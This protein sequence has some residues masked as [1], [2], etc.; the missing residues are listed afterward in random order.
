[1]M[2]F[3]LPLRTP[4]L[5]LE[6]LCAHG[7]CEHSQQDSTLAP[8][9]GGLW[10]CSRPPPA[11]ASPL[12]SISKHKATPGLTRWTYMEPLPLGK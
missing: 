10:N 8:G 4:A 5:L 7:G 1:M 2:M 9:L 3:L 11:P 6:K 12:G